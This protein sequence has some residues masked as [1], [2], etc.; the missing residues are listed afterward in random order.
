MPGTTSVTINEAKHNGTGEAIRQ[1]AKANANQS[2]EVV[3]KE[4]HAVFKVKQLL[5]QDG[6]HRALDH[7]CKLAVGA[8]LDM[9]LM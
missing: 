8:T 5:C 9:V 1:L 2:R 3:Y 7:A 4:A 6:N